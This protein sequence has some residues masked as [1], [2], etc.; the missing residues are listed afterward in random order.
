MENDLQKWLLRKF[1][2]KSLDGSHRPPYNK[3]E[4]KPQERPEEYTLLI[5]YWRPNKKDEIIELNI[6]E[7]RPSRE[8]QIAVRVNGV[9]I[10]G[11]KNVVASKLHYEINLMRLI[12][13]E[14][15]TNSSHL[16]SAYAEWEE[17]CCCD[18]EDE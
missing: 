16:G 5:S 13:A 3:A 17:M 2:Q 6:E 9:E 12:D 11:T 15:S 18:D 4:I 7:L 1:T 10:R 14:L 8:D